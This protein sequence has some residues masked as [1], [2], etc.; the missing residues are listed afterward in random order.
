MQILLEVADVNRLADQI[1][2]GQCIK[3]LR[4]ILP[5]MRKWIPPSSLTSE[6]EQAKF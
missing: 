2:E 4:E 1:H 3:A 5:A 6:A